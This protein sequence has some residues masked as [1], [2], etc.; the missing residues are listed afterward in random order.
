M[1]VRDRVNSYRERMRARG[2]RVVQHWFPDT[3]SAAFAVAAQEQARRVAASESAAED[4]EFTEQIAA[5][6]SE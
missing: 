5:E 1:A 4:L 2:F 6:W 3:R